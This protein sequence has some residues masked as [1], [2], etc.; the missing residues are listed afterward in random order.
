MQTLESLLQLTP[1]PGL[2]SF[3][4]EERNY[5]FGRERQLD[6]LLRKLRSN[7]FLAVV[8]TAG[9]GKS[10]L[11]KA[12]LV[13]RLHD[14][15]AGQA[16]Q[17]WR[18]AISSIGNNPIS[19]LAKQLA[20][21]GV[22]HADEM[23]DPNYPAVIENLLRRGNLGIVEAF[24][25]SNVKREN[26]MIVIDQ[27]DEIF[28]YAHKGSQEQEEAA[29]FVS[30]LLNASRQ[31]EYPIYVVLTMRSSAIGACTE[32]RGLP[33]S[34]NDGQFLIPRMK[35]EDLKKAVIAPAAAAAIEVDAEL[36]N[37]IVNDAGEDFD[38]LAVLQHTLMRTWYY[39]IDH[40]TDYDN[41]P[42]SSKH[43]EAVGGLN[44]ALAKHAEEAYAEL[45]TQDKQHIAERMFKALSEKGAD[46]RPMRRPQTMRELMHV[47]QASLKDISL[48]VHVFSQSGRE[49][50]SAPDLADI[51][52]DSTITI[53]HESFM[54]RWKRLAT[55]VDE[56]SASAETYLRMSEAAALYYENKGSL[57]RDP[58]LSLGLKWAKPAEYDFEHPDKL[59]PTEPWAQRYNQSF[60][61]T[62]AFLEESE[63]EHKAALARIASEQDSRMR[64]A[65]IIAGISVFGGL[66]CLLL[67]GVALMASNRARL[68]AQAAYRN[69]QSANRN[70][71]LAELSKQDASYQMSI[72]NI[73]AERAKAES[74]KA[75]NATTIAL[76]ALNNADEQARRAEIQRINALK[77]AERARKAQAEADKRRVEADQARDWAVSEQKKAEKATKE[78]IRVKTL[79]LA[80][81][82]AV[83]SMSVEDEKEEALLSKEA[84]DLNAMSDGKPYDAYIYEALYKSVDRLNPEF[85]SLQDAPKGVK[86]I[87]AIR[88]L[89]FT[90]DGQSIFSSGSE[91]YLLQWKNK[92]FANYNEHRQDANLPVIV[93]HTPTVYRAMAY[94]EDGKYLVRG[95]DN[96]MLEI[97][98]TEKK[99]ELVRSVR[100]HNGSRV[101]AMVLLNNKLIISAGADGNLY[102]TPISGKESTL[103]AKMERGSNVSADA[104]TI[105]DLALSPDGK[106]LFG[107]S[108]GSKSLTIW[109]LDAGGKVEENLAAKFT[110]V[111]S[112]EDGGK[113]DK[114]TPSSLALSP[115]GRYLAIGYSDGV[116][117]IWDFTESSVLNYIPEAQQYHGAKIQDLQ[118]SAN[119][120]MLA[121]ASLDKTASLWQIETNSGE[122]PYRDAKFTPIRLRDHDDW[123]MSVAFTK[124]GNR[125]ATGAANGVIKLWETDMFKYADEICQ[126]VKANLNDKSWRKY[127]GTDDPRNEMNPSAA[128]L[129]IRTQDGGVRKPFSTCGANFDQLPDN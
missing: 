93:A 107:I 60:F 80:Q 1:Y 86:R 38:D 101:T 98:S 120:K 9:S 62:I 12:S 56:E 8:G 45:D 29:S 35:T 95:G 46:G 113:K 33:E 82:I 13:P 70:L 43:Y 94:T 25:Q 10:S 104:A 117:R 27:F 64:R 55:W 51:D 65:T 4:P 19:A 72:A 14:G 119:S 129:Y 73:M 7:R 99:N 21:R 111:D 116:I 97:Y 126:R 53:A 125:L 69:E 17:Q 128:D 50:L 87:G 39:W 18:I 58:E 89:A 71:Y 54:E 30:L 68:S 63:K 83:K 6:E 23:M 88:S 66:I 115:N 102:T 2:R 5:F 112:D 84:Y 49:F 103:F 109:N 78:A 75:N 110:P 61:E 36:A 26:L 52:E 91:G 105:I 44:N 114:I 96:G 90:P 37:R 77:E 31:K 32:F 92:T 124:D 47:T 81:S 121:A 11:V 3:Q 100:A 59:A 40:A 118:F 79:S 108:N 28:R 106:Y 123:V 85:N 16:G 76:D 74:E 67:L 42:I 127:I 22:L 24:K 41:T 15:F 20:Q 34:I 122:Q 57:W 48:V